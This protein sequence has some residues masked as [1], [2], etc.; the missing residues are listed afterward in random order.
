MLIL[1]DDTT[2][3]SNRDTR[4]KERRSLPNYMEWAWFLSCV[5]IAVH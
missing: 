5:T 4:I 3:S 1:Y 2:I